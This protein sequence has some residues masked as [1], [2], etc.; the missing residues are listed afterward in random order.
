MIAEQARAPIGSHGERLNF[1]RQLAYIHFLS[2][3][4]GGLRVTRRLFQIF[5]PLLHQFHDPIAH[6]SGPIVEFQRCGGKKAASGENLLFAIAQPILAKSSQTLESTE[7]KCRADYLFDEDIASFVNYGALQIFLGT[8][9]GEQTALADAKCRSQ[10]SNRQ[11]FEPFERG[12][13]DSLPQDR[14]SRFQPP[15]PPKWIFLHTTSGSLRSPGSLLT[16]AHNSHASY[17]STIVRS[18]T[19]GF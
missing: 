3:F 10:P 11:P 2:H 4:A 8:E 16:C 17:N 18:I 19:I 6:A 14:P 1:E 13:V 15:R 7:L 12:E 9:V 5:Q